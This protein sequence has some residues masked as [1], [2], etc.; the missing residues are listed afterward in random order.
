M[1]KIPLNDDAVLNLPDCWEDLTQEQ[2]FFTVDV[3]NRLFQQTITPDT[4][5]I[6]LLLNYTN[7]RPSLKITDPDTRE[8]INFNLLQLSE[9]LNFAFTV[10]GL[11]IRTNFAFK[12]N[13]LPVLTIEGINYTGK[14][15]NRDVT[16]KTDITAKEFV[17]AFDLYFASARSTDES[18]KGECLNQLCAILYP[19][20]STHEKNMVSGQIEKMSHADSRAKILISIWFAGI[21]RYY[22]EHPVYGILFSGRKT[23]AAADKISLGMNEISL[24]LK[25]EGY[26]D[27]GTMNLNDFFDAQVKSLKDSISKALGSGA[28]IE[29]LVKKT[30]L[31]IETLNKLS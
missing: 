13:P 6:E 10:D 8:T 19:G 22:T 12:R 24:Y 31:S 17:D 26:G 15:F 14:K 21:I 3:L 4:A 9:Q 25:K 7:Y 29:E 23:E 5:R 30:G 1:K 2:L 16:A 11:F 27:P 20:E 18:I 28:K